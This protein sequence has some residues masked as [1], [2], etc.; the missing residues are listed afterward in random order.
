MEQNY[1][2]KDEKAFTNDETAK[3]DLEATK[4][5][6]NEQRQLYQEEDLKELL[7]KKTEEVEEMNSKYL[8]ISADFQNYKRRVE[9][10]KSE[11]HSYANEKLILELLPAIDNLER[12]VRS[13]SE[14]GNKDEAVT[15]GIEMILQQFLDTMNNN[16][17]EEIKALGE[18]FD[19]NRH[20]AVMQEASGS[21]ETNKVLEV[22]Q[23]G[24][25]LN[26][27]VIRPS[28]VK[29]SN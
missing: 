2:G 20:H 10:E 14:E 12:A 8:R 4:E 13:I 29:V 23:K 11:L 19:P 17:L 16:G 25:A 21:E 28:M 22:Y 7:A 26:G 3:S 1:S 24:Y 18:D 6:L 9:K 15:K 27:K 5:E